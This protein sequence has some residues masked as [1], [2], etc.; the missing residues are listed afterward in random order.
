MK[1][2][3]ELK[4]AIEVVAVCLVVLAGLLITKNPV[5]LWGIAFAVLIA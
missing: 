4:D 2:S 1:I 3:S 5:C